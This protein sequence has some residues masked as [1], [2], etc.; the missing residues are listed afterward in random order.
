M[1]RLRSDAGAKHRAPRGLA[2]TQERPAITLRG[3]PRR[4]K[5]RSNGQRCFSAARGRPQ[6]CLP[7]RQG[8]RSGEGAR[9]RSRCPRGTQP[10]SKRPIEQHSA[11][12]WQGSGGAEP[13]GDAPAHASPARRERAPCPLH[14][15]CLLP[16]STD[17]QDRTPPRRRRDRAA[18]HQGLASLSVG[19]SSAGVQPWLVPRRPQPERSGG[20]WP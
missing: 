3:L 15:Q 12:A 11:A 18:D 5:R 9:A 16:T 14:A 8:G 6:L 19:A 2:L 20:H 7:R 1:S 4:K 13:P 10:G 17:G